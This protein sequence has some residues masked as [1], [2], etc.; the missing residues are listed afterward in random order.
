MFRCSVLCRSLT[1][2]ARAAAS[3]ARRAT[4]ARPAAS[5]AGSASSLRPT[6]GSG[7]LCLNG[8][9]TTAGPAD[10]ARAAASTALAHVDGRKGTWG[11]YVWILLV[12]FLL[13]HFE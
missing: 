8:F 6:T 5:R 12:L 10:L 7:N 11:T 3:A 1:G 9:A 4:S 2:V 13:K